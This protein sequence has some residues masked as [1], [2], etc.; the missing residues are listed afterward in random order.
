MT[1]ENNRR[2]RRQDKRTRKERTTRKGRKVMKSVYTNSKTFL[3]SRL[4]QRSL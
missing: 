2:S 4:T 1:G 3:G